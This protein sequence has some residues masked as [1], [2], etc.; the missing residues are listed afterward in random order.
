MEKLE[1]LKFMFT[2]PTF[3]RNSEIPQLLNYGLVVCGLFET[4]LRKQQ[5]SAH[6]HA[7]F[8]LGEWRVSE[9]MH[10]APFLQA[11]YVRARHLHK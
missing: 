10:E 7:L 2:H 5:A 3:N 4:R 11:A 9:R 1:R 8:H 6:A